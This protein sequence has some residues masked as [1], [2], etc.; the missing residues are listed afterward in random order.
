MTLGREQ[1]IEAV[2][3]AGGKTGVNGLRYSQL[4][5]AYDLYGTRGVEDLCAKHGITERAYCSPCESDTPTFDGA[6]A[7][8]G[9][10][11]A[12]T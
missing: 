8:C 10:A 9:S 1:Q 2:T 5:R 12:G 3:D 6:C 7:V 11:R 4:V